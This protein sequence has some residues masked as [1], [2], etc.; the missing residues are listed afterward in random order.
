MNKDLLRAEFIKRE[1]A[2]RSFVDFMHY[3]HPELSFD[4]FHT[5]YYSLLDRFAHG[6]VR[7]IIITCPPQH[8][9]QLSDDTPVLTDCGWKNHGDLQIGDK[10][11]SPSGKFVKV[12]HVFPKYSQ[13]CKVTFTN[14]EELYCHENHEWV[15]Y[16]RTAHKERVVE[17]KYIEDHIS[18]GTTKKVRGHRYNFQLPFV[19]PIEG[20]YKDLCV[21]PYVLGAW[22]GDG[23]GTDGVICACPKDRV[24][25]DECR[26]YYPNGSEC[27]HKQTKVLYAGLNGLVTDLHKYNMGVSSKR[28]PKYIPDEYLTSSL[29]QRLDLLAGLLDTDGFLYKKTNRYTFT[30]VEAE[31]KDTFISLISTFGW[32]CSVYEVQPSLSASGIQGKKAYWKICFNP[33]FEIPC[34]IE[35]K[36]CTNF[37]KQRKISIQSVTRCETKIGNCISVEGGVYLAGKTLIPTHN[38]EA[39]TRNLPAYMHGLNPDLRICIASYGFPLAEGFNRAVKANI[40]STKYANIFPDTV[41]SK[42]EQ[43]K[44]LKTVYDPAI[45]VNNARNYRLLG[46]NGGLIATGRGGALTGNPVDIGIIDDLYKD[47]TEANS[48]L[49]RDAAWNWYVDVFRTRLHNDSQELITFTRWHEDDIIGR[50]RILC[51]KER[52]PFYDIESLDQLKNCDPHAWY[53]INFEAIKESLPTDIDNREKGTVLWPERHSLEKLIEQRKLDPGRFQ[54]L[55]QGNPMPKEGLLYTKEFAMFKELPKTHK[56]SFLYCDVADKGADY[57]C[58]LPFIKTMDNK[59]MFHDILYTQEGTEVTEKQVAD[60]IIRNNVKIAWIESN[61]GGTIFARNV[62]KLIAAEHYNCYIYD[63]PQT[64][65]KESRILTNAVDVMEHCMFEEEWMLKYPEFYRDIKGFKRLFAA[66]RHDDAPDALTGATEQSVLG[67]SF[68]HMYEE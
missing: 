7:K 3:L 31:L 12:T 53:L 68:A 47:D 46:K 4:P 25:I 41:L 48:P 30:T 44:K 66:N 14:G 37:S 1:L 34:R 9:K 39:S 51:Q 45:Y 16:D 54:S 40:G 55:Y 38:S 26:K 5:A 65:N 49:I 32:R 27:E 58:A 67:K 50:L 19:A 15:V 64:Q 13:D 8:G 11:L 21:P 10:V 35:R 17:T 20:S 28:M 18:Y 52:T 24:V 62:K 22:L 42:T 2:K 43:A 29:E 59:L 60:R 36:R 56:G 33:T 6:E 61:S 63:I 57:M 23:K